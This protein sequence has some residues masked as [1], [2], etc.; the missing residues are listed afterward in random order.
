MTRIIAYTAGA[1]VGQT[2]T[3]YMSIS[4]D[5]ITTDFT[6]TESLTRNCRSLHSGNFWKP[7]QERSGSKG[8]A[9]STTKEAYF[10]VEGKVQPKQR[11]KVYA[12][13][14]TGRVHG[15]TPD[16]TREYEAKV[17]ASYAQEYGNT[18][19]V[20][21]LEMILNVY[22]SI[23]KGVSRKTRDRMLIGEIRP[24]T[25]TGDIDNLFKAIADSLNGLAYD[26]DSQIV[27]GTIRKW[28]SNE[29]KA[30]ITIREVSQ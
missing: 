27:D 19:F 18:K 8:M 4:A 24:A 20:G 16:A 14:Y 11:P 3:D 5:F 1:G 23:P 10:I 22:V 15:V 12:N 7:I 29:P 25:H 28:Y 2:A 21:A 9:N 6:I 13:K 17:R 30:E 26:D